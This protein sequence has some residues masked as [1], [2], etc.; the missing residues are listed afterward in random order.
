MFNKIASLIL[1]IA[2]GV[3]LNVSINKRTALFFKTQEINE[4]L[5][6][7]I[8]KNDKKCKLKIEEIKCSK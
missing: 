1:G 5:E 6:N 7:K 4:I 2:I 8:T 3:L